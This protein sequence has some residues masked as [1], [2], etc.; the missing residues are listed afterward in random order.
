MKTIKALREEREQLIAKS[1]AFIALATEEK[2]ELTAEETAEIDAINSDNGLIV[3]IDNQIARLEKVEARAK[4]IA[5]ASANIPAVHSGN[6]S[7][8]FEVPR[9]ERGYK[10]KNF[11]DTADSYLAGRW[12]AATIFDHK[13][14]RHWLDSNGF[15]IYNS[16]STSNNESAGYLVPSVL[17]NSIITHVPRYGAFARNV[18]MQKP[19]VNGSWSG[20]R[21]REGVTF[22]YPAEESATT[23]STPKFGLV[24]LKANDAVALIK[25]SRNLDQDAISAMGDQISSMFARGIA[26]AQDQAGFLGDGGATYGGM[27]GLKNALAAGCDVTATAI[28]TFGALTMEN[29]VSVVGKLPDWPGAMPKWYISKPGYYASMARLQ[30]AGGGNAVADLGNGPVLQFLGYPV[31]FVDVLP[32]ALTTLT[33][34][35]V[36]Y[37]GDLSYAAVMGTARNMTVEADRS[38]YFTQRQI[39]VQAFTRYDIN[40]YEVGTASEAGGMIALKMG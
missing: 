15:E 28:T 32:K 30:L 39:A 27:T 16:L 23:E 12:A 26:L 2:R 1:Q 31:E 10:P 19:L 7:A 21:E 25:V 5:A 36:A 38:V 4:Q 29:F 9:A 3:Q 13:E 37:F 33:G 6:D 11:A 18:G 35:R 40:V 22:Y 20:P 8:T 14:S 24:S 17:E 34:Q